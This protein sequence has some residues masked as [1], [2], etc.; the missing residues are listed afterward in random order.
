MYLR[1]KHTFTATHAEVTE[2]GIMMTE[3]WRTYSKQRKA[4]YAY[5]VLIAK[6]ERKIQPKIEAHVTV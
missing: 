4:T 1:T 6:L 3:L 2:T 5:R